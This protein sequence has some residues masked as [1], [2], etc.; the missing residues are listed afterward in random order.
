MTAL[1][2]PIASIDLPVFKEGAFVHE[3]DGW[4]YLSYGYR[5]PQRVAYATSRSIDGPWTFQGIVTRYPATARRTDRRS[6]S[7]AVAGTSSTK[8]V[9]SPDAGA[10]GDRCASTVRPMTPT[11][12]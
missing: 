4:L 5:Y 8:T 2:E 10:T 12:A 11:G 7:S 9:C 1:T 6:P 3:R